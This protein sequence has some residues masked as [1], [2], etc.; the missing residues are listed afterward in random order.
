[1][2]TNDWKKNETYYQFVERQAKEEGRPMEYYMPNLKD[3][4]S[5]KIAQEARKFE[6]AEA[7]KRAAQGET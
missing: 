7:A 4:V 3:N 2:N 1:M 5:Q 6:E